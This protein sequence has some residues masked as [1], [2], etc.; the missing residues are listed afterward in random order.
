MGGR[1]RKK[2]LHFWGKYAVLSFCCLSCD[3]LFLSFFSCVTFMPSLSDL[4]SLKMVL[5]EFYYT[6]VAW[7]IEFEYMHPGS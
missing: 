6:F 4:S 2:T 3:P 7:V 5:V 1:V